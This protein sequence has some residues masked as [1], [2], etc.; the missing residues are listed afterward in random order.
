MGAMS[1]WRLISKGAI[2]SKTCVFT[3]N[4][5]ATCLINYLQQIKHHKNY[6]VEVKCLLWDICTHTSECDW[7][8]QAV[9]YSEMIYVHTP[10]NV[11]DCYKLLPTVSEMVYDNSEANEVVRRGLAWSAAWM[12]A[13]HKN[14]QV[15]FYRVMQLLL[16]HP[17]SPKIVVRSFFAILHC[18]SNTISSSSSVC[19]VRLNSRGGANIIDWSKI[20]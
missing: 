4:F 1:R 7:L 5:N 14:I 13:I 16:E 10:V 12:H 20:K 17:A 19:C 18:R 6:R 8:L 9:T 2:I 3:F 11:T 15:C